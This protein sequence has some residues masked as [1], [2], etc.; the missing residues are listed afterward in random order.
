MSY[1]WLSWA[2]RLQAIAKNG[3]TFTTNPFDVERFRE[4]HEI[5]C[6]IMARH[7]DLDA[8]SA[9]A[10]FRGEKGYATPKVDV[11]GFTLRG[12]NLLMIKE[13]VDGLWSLPGGWADV[14]VSPA[15]AVVKE[16]FEESGYHA[17]AVRLLAVYDRNKHG[18][19]PYPFHAYKL[20][21]HC[22][23]T[24]G[25]PARS[26][27]TEDVDFFD[28]DRLPPL[29]IGRVTEAQIRRLTLLAGDPRSAADF[30]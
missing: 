11:R 21:F 6:E 29:S 1:E 19:T 20:F 7:S 30:D 14:N 27:E 25:S 9:H 23:L 10:L 28:L 17:R 8:D 24:G 26:I 4:I 13:K 12:R 2:R 16:I 5:A 3:L 22:E 15:E 18:H